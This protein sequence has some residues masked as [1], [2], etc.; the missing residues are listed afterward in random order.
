MSSSFVRRAD[1]AIVYPMTPPTSSSGSE[2]VGTVGGV[3]RP[4]R[5]MRFAGLALT[6]KGPGVAVISRHDQAPP[7]YVP[8]TSNRPGPSVPRTVLAVGS[9]SPQAQSI[10][11]R[12][13][14]QAQ[15]G[16]MTGIPTRVTPPR[17]PTDVHGATRGGR[18]A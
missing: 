3:G 9:I 5:D 17:L 8:G 7:S 18:P 10:I 13:S 1:K 2:V 16:V 11:P 12:I 6:P 14:G 4:P 15:G